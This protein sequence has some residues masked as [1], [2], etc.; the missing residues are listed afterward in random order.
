MFLVFFCPS[1]L[2]LLALLDAAFEGFQ[3][4]WLCSWE[5]CHWKQH[6]TQSLLS[7]IVTLGSGTEFWALELHQWTHSLYPSF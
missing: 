5:A 1:P 3:N 6:C 2:C 4:V 7:P